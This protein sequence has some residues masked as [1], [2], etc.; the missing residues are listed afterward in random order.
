MKLS[1][2][3]G[4]HAVIKLDKGEGFE[5]CHNYMVILNYDENEEYT[6]LDGDIYKETY[7]EAVAAAN[8]W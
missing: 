3:I 2:I 7:K 8:S 6:G 1:K 5:E 4:N